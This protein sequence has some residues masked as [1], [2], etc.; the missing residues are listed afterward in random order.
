MDIEPTGRRWNDVHELYLDFNGKY[1]KIFINMQACT[2]YG[3]S[4]LKIFKQFE[5]AR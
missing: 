2:M 1:S 3:Y 4:K 5:N